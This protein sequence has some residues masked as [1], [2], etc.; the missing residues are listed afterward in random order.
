LILKP[1]HL[2]IVALSAPLS[3][4]KHYR[5]PQKSRNLLVLLE[6]ETF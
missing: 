3:T 2:D 4:T 6:R 5:V 1:R